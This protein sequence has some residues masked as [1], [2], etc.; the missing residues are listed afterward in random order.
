MS[1]L[2]QVRTLL[3]IVTACSPEIDDT[4]F[5]ILQTI[6]NLF[7]YT[8]TQYQT[9]GIIFNTLQLHVDG[10]DVK[11][12]INCINYADHLEKLRQGYYQTVN[13]ALFFFDFS[14]PESLEAIPSY[15]QEIT[16]NR[17]DIPMMIAGI[18]TTDSR[19]T[20]E[21]AQSLADSLQC[22]YAEIHQDDP[23]DLNCLFISFALHIMEK[24]ESQ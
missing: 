12:I 1:S 22:E 13:G 2:E 14:I 19:I 8:P 9:L 11:L 24:L 4:R 3:N 16:R 6:M 17:G 5:N 10:Q 7:P 18:H 20:S 21:E 23:E 15:H